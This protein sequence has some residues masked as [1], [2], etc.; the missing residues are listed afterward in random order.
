M[1]TNHKLVSEGKGI[2]A[3][4]KEIKDRCNFHEH[5]NEEGKQLC[6]SRLLQDEPYIDAL[7]SVCLEA[8]KSD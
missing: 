2:D 4:R 5:A 7:I 8:G 1:H 3:L 6:K